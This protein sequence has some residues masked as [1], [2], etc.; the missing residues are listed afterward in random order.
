MATAL[1]HP[2]IAVPASTPPHTI[3]TAEHSATTAAATSPP[4]PALP[5]RIVSVPPST[6]PPTPPAVWPTPLTPG[7]A[8][9]A[10]TMPHTLTLATAPPSSVWAG[11]AARAANCT[12]VIE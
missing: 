3:H 10:A 9:P 12:D 1:Q 2:L 8:L 4:G 6:V 5:Q 11:T 7:A